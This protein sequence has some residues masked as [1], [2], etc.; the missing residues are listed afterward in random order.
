MSYANEAL[1]KASRKVDAALNRF[2]FVV[3]FTLAATA[4]LITTEVLLAAH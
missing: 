3:V 1:E 4:L 2:G